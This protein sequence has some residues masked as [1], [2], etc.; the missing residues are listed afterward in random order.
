MAFVRQVIAGDETVSPH[1]WDIV[2]QLIIDLKAHPY[3]TVFLE[4]PDG[5]IT[6][7]YVEDKGYVISA[8]GKGEF[9]EWL[10]TDE[11]L[12]GESVSVD[13]ANH[14]TEVP[15]NVLVSDKIALEVVKHFYSTGLRSPDHT[16]K[17]SIDLR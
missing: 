17:K 9:Y 4:G 8:F 14:I 6:M 3:A 5:Q 1:S 2:K 10:S 13:I 12:P 15:R 16:W 11:Q 7:E